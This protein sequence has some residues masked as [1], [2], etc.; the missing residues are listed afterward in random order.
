MCQGLGLG[1][2]DL[3]IRL[4]EATGRGY[5]NILMDLNQT[6]SGPLWADNSRISERAFGKFARSQGI[7]DWNAAGLVSNMTGMG[8]ET[9]HQK[10]T[11]VDLERIRPPSAGSALPLATFQ[12]GAGVPSQSIPLGRLAVSPGTRTRAETSWT[13]LAGESAYESNRTL[14][15]MIRDGDKADSARLRALQGL[16]ENGAEDELF[17]IVND[18]DRY[19]SWRL[20]ALG[21]LCDLAAGSSMA[22]NFLNRLVHNSDRYDSWRVKALDRLCEL[23]R[24]SSEAAEYLF[25]LVNNSD[26]YDSW[27]LKALRALIQG[28]H[29]EYLRRIAANSDRYNSWRREAREALGE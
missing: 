5:E 25:R 8:L 24:D 2:H 16:I 1:K 22:M 4:S 17:T 23:A 27:R 28:G 29:R 18:S 15:A 9:A 12:R 11:A 21:T 26:R 20:K 13:A 6:S 14:L 3:A 10:L 19:D 7:S